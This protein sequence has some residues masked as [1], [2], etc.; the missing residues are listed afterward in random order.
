MPTHGTVTSQISGTGRIWRI[1]QPCVDAQIEA[2]PEIALHPNDLVT[3]TAGGGVQTGGSGDTWKRYV[4]P[5]GPNADFFYHGRI[6]IPGVHPQ[7]VRLLDAIGAPLWIPPY[8]TAGP[9]VL[10]LGYEDDDYSDNGYWGHDN[11][12][13]GQTANLGPAWITLF[14]RP[15]PTRLAPA[16]ILDLGGIP[17]PS[18]AQFS[19]PD[20]QHDWTMA[21]T[22]GLVYEPQLNPLSPSLITPTS[23]FAWVQIPAPADATTTHPVAVC[24][25]ALQPRL[26]QSD[27]VFNHLFGIDFETFIALDPPYESALAP[28]NSGSVDSKT[29]LPNDYR[30]ARDHGS[31]LLGRQLP[32]V[33]GLEWEAALVPPPFQPDDG[34]RIATWGR[35]VVDAGHLEANNQGFHCEIHPPLLMVRANQ[36]GSGTHASLVG[37]PFGTIEIY[38]DGKPLFGHM[39]SEL[40]KAASP[41]IFAT[42]RIEAH[43]RL[44]TNPFPAGRSSF[45]F[46]LRT[47]T[48]RPGGGCPIR[49]NLT[50]RPGVTISI[51][52]YDTDTV[53][54]A[55]QLDRNSYQPPAAPERLDFAV[56]VNDL[57]Q[58]KTSDVSILKVAAFGTGLLTAAVLS[59]G[60][61][62]PLMAIMAGMTGLH[63]NSIV[64][65]GLLTDRYLMPPP[66]APP[67]FPPTATLDTLP[68]GNLAKISTAIPWPMIGTIDLG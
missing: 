1:D 8:A 67:L 47:P 23:P 50:C 10:R 31:Q 4:D 42:Q 63:F 56:G 43:A 2:Y 24:G 33:L 7:P 6:A 57:D 53:M 52:R 3:V 32:G 21:V 66:P 19:P 60:L 46:F 28:A 44:D 59:G 15:M 58:L 20:A 55:V 5:R 12:W 17:G 30:M 36:G 14:V 13:G 64:T 49:W 34:D 54:V 51:S 62:L 38:E 35:W 26:S 18:H 16:R 45:T 65:S 9:L 37:N 48:P 68:S 39:V 29:N 25:T 61:S 41:N 22:K 40:E 27:N 11:G